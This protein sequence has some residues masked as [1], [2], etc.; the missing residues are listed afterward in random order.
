MIYSALA[1]GMPGWLRRYL[2]HFET[3]IE[4]ATAAFAGSLPPRSRVLDAGAG[5][6]Q[7]AHLFQ[8]HRYVSVDLGIGDAQW[9]YT[10]LNCV[11]DLAAL[12]LA[13]ASFDACINIVT[14][15]HV[16]DPAQVLREI[17]RILRTGGRIL[18]VAPLEWEVHQAPH[19]YFRYTCH[20][21]RHLLAQAGFGSIEVKACG[22]YFR[23]LSRRLLNGL[24][25]F[26]GPFFFL[27]AL[28]LVPPAL[29]LPLLDGLDHHRDFTLGYL[30][31][32]SKLS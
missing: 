28:F 25:F 19:D 4:S 13:N 29:V 12:P 31:T 20:G 26:P 17:S 6:L 10:R 18:L 22:G 14:L 1:R 23:L 30:C 3:S 11:A 24:Q 9:D 2:L 27:A 16:T 15:E 8:S 7:Y 5:E 32:A 21:I